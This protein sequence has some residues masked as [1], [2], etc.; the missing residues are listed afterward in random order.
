MAAPHIPALTLLVMLTAA[1][2]AAAQWT[3]VDQV[4][5][6]TLFTVWANGDTI[7]AGADSTVLI[8]TDGGGTWKISATVTHDPLEVERVRV[9]NGRVYAGTRRKGVFVSDD[10]GA[11]WSS[12]NQ[13]LVGGFADSQLDV[14]DM[15]IRGDSLYLA[16]EGGGA[17]VRN[18]VAGTW[19]LFGNIFAPEQSTNM[20]LIASGGSRLLAG[21]GF[22]GE[23]FFRDPGQPDWTPTLLF[24]DRFAAGLASLSAIWTGSRWV[25]GA[26]IG[27]F[28]SAQGQSPWTFVD[29][30]A[31]RPLF[32][33]PLAMRGHD[34]FAAFSA[35]TATIS[36]SRD[37][38]STWQTLETVSA[39]SGLA[40]HANTL[41]ASRIDGLWRRSLE[42][43]PNVSVPPQA[44]ALRFAITG[45]QPVRDGVRFR[46]ELPA[47]GLAQ[48]E[49]FD[50]AGRHVASLAG[51]IYPAGASEIAWNAQALAPGVY[52]ARLTAGPQTQALRFVRVP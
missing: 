37:E 24:N 49:V 27:I 22:N 19:H 18:L 32:T 48:I 8:S 26:N 4:P 39:T 34:L 30:G 11:T 28:L 9:R 40:V 46:F 1:S 44:R 45:R 51:E 52:H 14:I 31:G 41:Y 21:G 42:D 23:M 50:L 16:T 7:A 25:V 36:L 20:T 13:G 38:G 15:M 12:F 35:G 5:G 2:P 29:P 6:A 3:R 17:W 43:I 33:V 10:L 47:P